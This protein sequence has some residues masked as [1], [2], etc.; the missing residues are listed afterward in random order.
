M[1]CM[2]CLCFEETSRETLHNARFRLLFFFF[3]YC[4][5]SFL[6]CFQHLERLYVP[7][8]AYSC[9]LTTTLL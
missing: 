6:L 7:L 9:A 2:R 5:K 4:F 3:F 8:W 1:P